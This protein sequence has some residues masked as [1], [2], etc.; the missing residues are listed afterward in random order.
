MWPRKT[1]CFCL[2]V[3]KCVIL[4]LFQD[5]GHRNVVTSSTNAVFTRFPSNS[6][7]SLS[8]QASLSWGKKVKT[9]TNRRLSNRRWGR[10]CSQRWAKLTSTIKS[11][12]TPSLS[13]NKNHLKPAMETYT[14]RA[15]STRSGWK[16]TSQAEC[17]Q[18][19]ASHWEFKR[20]PLLHGCTTCRDT[21]LLQPI[22]SWR[23]L[24]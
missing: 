11:Y 9:R 3:S 15:R 23:F 18:P 5:T 21:G 22:K 13:T 6:L 1:P 20:T 8:R 10:D 17:H 4:Y 19:Y 14:T 7:S 12:M 2:N 16:T 24:E